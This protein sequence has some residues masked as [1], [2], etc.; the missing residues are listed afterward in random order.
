MKARVL[1]YEQAVATGATHLFDEKYGDQVRVVCFGDWTCEFCGG[2]H[3]ASTA[4][5]GLAVITSES[6]IGQGLRRLD[7]TVGEAA[8]ALVRRRLGLFTELARTLGVPPEKVG[9]RVLELRRELR[10]AERQVDRLRD[11]VRAAHVR[12][13]DGGPRRRLAKVPLILEEVPAGGMEDLRGWADRYLELLGGT[14]VVAVAGNSS[15]VIK[16]S[17]DLAGQYP[18][19]GLVSLL[20][21]GGG[22]PEMA[23]GRLTR[24]PGEAF[25]ELEASLR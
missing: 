25:E 16:V 7:L 22:R 21:R 15:F 5:V 12:G 4:D 8:E 20:G 10:D 1:P 6:S 2:T 17:R 11:E 3:V 19:T 24:N 23:Q 13:A 14:G 18:A 9:E